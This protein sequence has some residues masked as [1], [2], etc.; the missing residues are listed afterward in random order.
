MKNARNVIE[1]TGYKG[2]LGRGNSFY[3]TDL[4][5][6]IN[7]GARPSYGSWQRFLL[8]PGGPLVLKK[9]Q[10]ALESRILFQAVL[11]APPFLDKPICFCMIA[12]L[13]STRFNQCL[14]LEI[15]VKGSSCKFL[16]RPTRGI[17]E[18]PQTR[19]KYQELPGTSWNFLE[20]PH[21]CSEELPRS[22]SGRQTPTW[23][24]EL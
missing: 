19:R 9:R 17:E 7:S 23:E 22:S 10:R 16:T 12:F 24:Q 18:V 6:S 2:T 5:V 4:A 21:P 13:I 14:L 20:V 11:G 15:P 3:H 8:I 1:T